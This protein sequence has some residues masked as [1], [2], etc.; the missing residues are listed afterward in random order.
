MQET[1]SG[2]AET[3][4]GMVAMSSSNTWTSVGWSGLNSGGSDIK[5]KNTVTV[6]VF[7]KH[8]N[9]RKDINTQ[10]YG[11]EHKDTQNMLS[12]KAVTDTNE[13]Q[14]SRKSTTHQ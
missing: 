5:K 13:S 4:S 7:Q 3:S 12:M 1:S 2:L 9:R 14:A 6:S 8:M 10:N 11:S